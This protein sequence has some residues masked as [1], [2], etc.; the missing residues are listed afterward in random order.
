[1]YLFMDM[2]NCTNFFGC[3]IYSELPPRWSEFTRY[4]RDQNKEKK[5]TAICKCLVY[6]KME[7]ADWNVLKSSLERH[8]KIQCEIE[9]DSQ[10]AR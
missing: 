4:S 1:M 3:L 7:T 9:T 2:Q 8:I 10:T 5:L 6:K